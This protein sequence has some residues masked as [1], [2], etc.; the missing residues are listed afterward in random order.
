MRDLCCVAPFREPEKLPFQEYEAGAVLK[1][2]CLRVPSQTAF[3]HQRGH[4]RDGRAA[5][6]ERLQQLANG[7]RLPLRRISAPPQVTLAARSKV[8][9]RIPP[10][11]EMLR[12]DG[13]LEIFGGGLGEQ[14]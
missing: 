7:L 6:I 3:L 5:R 11:L 4:S 1:R 12:T 13:D 2:L 9:P 10:P 8:L 14:A